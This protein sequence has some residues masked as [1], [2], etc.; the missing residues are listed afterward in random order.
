M[1]D[2]PGS[3][4]EPAGACVNCGHQQVG[5]GLAVGG[6]IGEVHVYIGQVRVLPGLGALV[7]IGLGEAAGRLARVTRATADLLDRH[8]LPPGR[9]TDEPTAKGTDP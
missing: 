4:Y 6:D 3:A 2:G 8:V 1:T 5:S 7:R 9:P